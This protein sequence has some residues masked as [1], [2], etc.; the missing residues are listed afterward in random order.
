MKEP[1]ISVVTVCYNAADTIEQTI[2]SVLNQSYSNLEY[3]IVDGASTDHTLDI[4]HKY[5]DRISI[6]VSEPDNGIYDAFNKGVRLATGDFINFM[7]ADD[8]FSTDQA[9]SE[10]ANYLASNPDVLMLH[11]N[12]KVMNDLSGYWYIDGQFLTVEDMENGRMCPH[13]SVFAHKKLFEEFGG[14]DLKYKILADVDFTIKCF[15]TYEQLIA[16]IPLEIATF[17]LG[18]VSTHINYDK[19]LHTENAIIHLEHFNSIPRR[20]GDYLENADESQSNR[21]YKLWLES[22]LIGN[23]GA[24]SMLA[25]GN[26]KKVIIFGTKLTATFLYYNLDKYGIEVSYFLDNDQRMHGRQ[27]H[28]IQIISPSQLN[29]DTDATIIIS[30]ERWSAANIM[31]AQLGKQFANARIYTWQDLI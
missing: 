17:R 7:N 9:V 4:I 1:K 23:M 29:A 27:M 10:V 3:I 26:D 19:N 12:V 18:G 25:A 31:K 21:F 20:T 11:G 28:S 2:Q 5:M 6:I 16:Y 13:Q 14:F 24:A 22:L 30:I 15:K 8:F